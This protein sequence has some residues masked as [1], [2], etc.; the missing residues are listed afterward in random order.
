LY[1]G[2]GPEQEAI[3]TLLARLVEEGR[4]VARAEL[5]LFRT[6]F[7]RRL[8]RA[9]TGALLLLLGVIMGQAAA[10][11]LLV[12]LA[13]LL[14]PFI[15]LLGG[16]AVALGLG[17]GIAV[18][19][20][21]TGVRK[22]ITVVED[23]EEDD[24]E[25]PNNPVKPLDLLFERMRLRSRA[26]RDQLKQT[27]DETQTRLHPQMLIADLA[28]EVVDHAQ[29]MANSAI[30][31]LKRRPLRLMAIALG[32]LVVLFREPIFRMIGRL[33]RATERPDISYRKTEAGQPAKSRDEETS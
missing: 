24:G 17:I 18:W 33:G 22:L 6:D 2:S 10:V 32:A 27:V 23:I 12:T 13:F 19:A 15:G 1:Q 29:A 31:A 9:R 3:G 14:S 30:D 21:H 26:A 25:G 7:Y 16:S 8:A 4:A 20:I 5:A 28:D 11:T